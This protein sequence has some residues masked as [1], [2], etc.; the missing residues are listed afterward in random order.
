MKDG[1]IT[2]LKEKKCHTYQK[3]EKKGIFLSKKKKIVIK[4][5]P[6]NTVFSFI[7]VQADFFD[8]II[9]RSWHTFENVLILIAII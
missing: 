6:K 8:K 4:I 9:L 3:G 1:A 7:G 2:R 5:K